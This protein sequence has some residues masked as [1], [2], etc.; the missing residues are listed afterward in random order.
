M[1]NLSQPQVGYSL[2]TSVSSHTH[3]L[4]S[5]CSSSPGRT[6]LFYRRQEHTHLGKES[7]NFQKQ[8]WLNRNDG[9]V[10][11]DHCSKVSTEEVAKR[12][13]YNSRLAL[14]YIQSVFDKYHFYDVKQTSSS[15]EK[16][17]VYNHRTAY[18]LNRQF[19]SSQST[20]LYSKGKI[21]NLFNCGNYKCPVCC[22]KY[23]MEKRL[24][25]QKVLNW[26][27]TNDIYVYMVTLTV[28]HTR[29]DS[30]LDV[31][32]LASR[33]KTKLMKH[34]VIQNQYPVFTVSRQEEPY[35]KNGYHCHYHCLIGFDAPVLHEDKIKEQWVKI[36]KSEGVNISVENGL[37]IKLMTSVDAAA[38]YMCK[39]TKLDVKGVACEMTATETK[40]AKKEGMSMYEIISLASQN[41]WD[42]MAY[43]R[44][45]VEMLIIEYFS[46][47]K[48]RIFQGDKAYGQILKRLKQ[49]E[50]D[51]TSQSES[52]D[53]EELIENEDRIEIKS[54]TVYQLVQKKLWFK[55]LLIHSQHENLNNA[56]EEMY[57]FLGEALGADN[58]IVNGISLQKEYDNVERFKFRVR[59]LEHWKCLQKHK[60][61][62]SIK[63]AA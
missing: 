31:F 43:S 3:S 16:Y 19:D 61:N 11:A 29:N 8:N 59:E 28:P 5:Q 63:L 34:K 1:K 60:F 36:G 42:E 48:K 32:E 51:S 27:N 12:Q 38:D 22:H 46:A 7:N 58:D 18:C 49:E 6:Q 33:C 17:K 40:V 30:Y 41:R 25:I 23:F 47:K 2:S 4:H 10:G 56:L 44:R 45:K 52:E 39:E 53:K 15:I 54:T 24:E 14:N 57:M 21:S 9:D 26:A 37:D 35:T 62:D 55:I 20:Y 50:T 13:K